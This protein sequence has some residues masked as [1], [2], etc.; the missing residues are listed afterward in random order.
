MKIRMS[1][2]VLSL[3]ALVAAWL[4]IVSHASDN[5]ALDR[6]VQMFV[7]EVVPADH[8]SEIRHADIVA[9]IKPINATRSRVMLIAQGEKDAKLFGRASCVINRKG[10]IVVMYLYDPKPGQPAY[11][12]PRVFARNVDATQGSRTAFAD[13]TKPF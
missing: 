1:K 10:S 6:C 5:P 4:P 9:S 11:G 3:A 7:E 8:S 12:R 13:D 2:P